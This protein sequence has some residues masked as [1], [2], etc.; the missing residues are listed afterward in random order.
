MRIEFSFITSVIR[1]YFIHF[2]GIIAVGL[3]YYYGLEFVLSLIYFIII[4]SE[5]KNLPLRGFGINAVIYIL[6][7][8]IAILCSILLMGNLGKYVFDDNAIFILQYWCTPI[9]PWASLFT[10]PGGEYAF[11]YYVFVIWPW[12]GFIIFMVI[13]CRRNGNIN[14]KGS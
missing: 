9:Y 1:L 13:V 14:I 12:I 6:W 8:G 7:Q 5:I 11:S 10:H 2:F 3:G 4:V